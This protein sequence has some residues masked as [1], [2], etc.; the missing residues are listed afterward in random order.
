MA[1]VANMVGQIGHTPNEAAPLPTPVLPEAIDETRGV[2]APEQG[3]YWKKAT[4]TYRS[5]QLSQLDNQL[6]RWNAEERVKMSAAEVLRLALDAMLKRMEEE[7]EQVILELY[8]QELRELE[9][10]ETRKFGRSQ[11]AEAYLKRK[12]ML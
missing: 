5:T 10:A 9:Q 2:P 6:A 8:Q 1:D 3:P 4:A 11:G 12:R 7:P